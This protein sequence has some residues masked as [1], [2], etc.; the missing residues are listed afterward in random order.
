MQPRTWRT[1]G[2]LCVESDV[3]DADDD[4]AT[5]HH[6]HHHQQQLQQQLSDHRPRHP[7]VLTVC[8]VRVLSPHARRL[9]LVP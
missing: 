3:N 6:Y 1:R 9:V 7:I 5:D 4:N 2:T 8:E